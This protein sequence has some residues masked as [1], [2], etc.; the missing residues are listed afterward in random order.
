[1]ADTGIFCTTEQVQRKAGANASSVSNTEAY[2]NDFVGQAE[3]MINSVTRYNWSDQYSTLNTDTRQL[4]TLAASSY[5]AMMVINYDMSGF[6]GSQAQVMLDVLIDQW[7]SSIKEL[8]DI[9]VRD[10]I[11][12]DAP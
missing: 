7:N 5:A 3:S 11:V 8:N 2:I 10:F 1:M 12:A 6:S 4:L 9:K